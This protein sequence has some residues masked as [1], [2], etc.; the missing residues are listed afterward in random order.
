MKV[1]ILCTAL[2]A[3][4]LQVFAQQ[5][6]LSLF[7]RDAVNY[8]GV[9]SAVEIKSRKGKESL[10]TSRGGL[11][12][13]KAEPGRY[14]ISV[15]AQGFKPLKTFFVVEAGKEIKADILLD[16]TGYSEAPAPKT[17]LAVITGYVIDGASGLPVADV[18]V[19]HDGEV[20]TSTDEKGFFQFESAK[21]SPMKESTDKPVR[22]V[23]SFQKEGYGKYEETN[24]PMLP[25]RMKMFITLQPGN[26]AV[27]KEYR[28]GVLDADKKKENEK[29]K[30][31]SE[32]LNG[33]DPPA[34]LACLQLPGSIRV[35][36]SCSCTSCSNVSVMTLENYAGSGLDD[37]WIASWHNNS[38]EAGS[39]AYRS[40]GAWYVLN[41]VNVNYD[42]ASTTCNQAWGSTVYTSSQNAAANMAGVVIEYNGNIARSEYSAENNNKGCG[43][44]WSGTSST[45]PCI[46]DGV[47]AGSSPNGHGRGM[48]QWGSQRWANT[49]G[50]AS[51]WILDH[52]YNPGNMYVNYP[53]NC[54]PTNLGIAS[55]TCPV[56]GVTLSWT[57]SGTGWFVDISDD[58]NFSYFWNKDVTGL[59]SVGCPGGFCDYPACT[60][61]L[62]F[63]P[64]T[65]YYWRIWDGAN[66]TYGA[67]F[68]T[69]Y[70]LTVDN[71][72]S[73]NIFD[74]G[75]P[76]GAHAGNEDWEY[77]IEPTNAASVSL[78]FNSFD[79]EV[80]SDFLDIYDGNSTAAPLIG[81]YSGNTNPG[82][83]VGNSGALT[84]RFTSDPFVNNNGFD[85]SWS[86]TLSSTAVNSLSA[87]G[88][89]QL[90]AFPN[91][92]GNHFTVTYSLNVESEVRIALVDMIGREV[93]VKECGWQAA[94]QH[95]VILDVS[96]G[97]GRGVYFLKLRSGKQSRCVKVVKE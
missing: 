81:S 60:S 62:Q 71:N 83:I 68:T 38:L 80:A 2:L 25:G 69:P 3:I 45:W 1:K 20:R 64:N 29:E 78:T 17:D 57:N 6:T 23:L 16:R 22:A 18:K 88:S 24:V 46:S 96:D 14:D 72:C 10:A 65:T 26:E 15:T 49:Q 63:Q 58:P 41:P 21:V 31:E 13:Y 90:A 27:T 9:E 59:T 35:G 93:L 95:T 86:C 34:P 8:Y 73:G 40:Y 67:S 92:F 51:G 52:Y 33:G 39:V 79:L 75:G 48:C 30:N 70:C 85:A 91:P 66:H 82:T 89:Q 76:T 56:I 36:T 5:G 43:D 4:S 94:A 74:S 42:I 50:Q 61:Y 47:C 84:L 53:S 12:T 55:G 37:E 7:V 11:L 77:V 28:H 44:G 87:A 19:R 32:V 54:S 97:L